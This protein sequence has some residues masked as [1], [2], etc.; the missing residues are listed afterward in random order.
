MQGLDIFRA[1]LDHFL[2][3]ILL[4]CMSLCRVGT[5]NENADAETDVDPGVLMNLLF[6]WQ[7]RLLS[8]V[9]DVHIERS[10]HRTEL[11]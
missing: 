3:E 2:E 10:E 7:T 9:S 11:K 8:L 4:Y 1:Y 6:P 5:C